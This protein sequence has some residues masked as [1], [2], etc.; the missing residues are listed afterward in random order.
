MLQCF[1]TLSYILTN[2]TV[3]TSRADI[4]IKDFKKYKCSLTD[5]TIPFDKKQNISAE[6]FE[7]FSKYKVLKIEIL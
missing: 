4:V 2:H 5:M 6:E 1:G 7:K 3:Q